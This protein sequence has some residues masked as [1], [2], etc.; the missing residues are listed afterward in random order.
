LSAMSIGTNVTRQ[1]APGRR[2]HAVVAAPSPRKNRLLAALP[3]PEYERVLRSLIP[4]QLSS[5]SVLHDAGDREKHLYFITAGIVSR[6]YTLA[7]GSSTGFAVTGNEGVVGIPSFLG[8]E[9]TLSQAVV[10]GAGHAYRM[11]TQ[12]AQDLFLSGG[13][14]PQLLLRFTQALI[15]QIGQ[16]AVCNRHHHLESQLCRWILSCLDRLPENK[17]SMTQETIAGMLGVRREG[18]TEAAGHLQKAG[19]I[20][21]HRG[22]ISVFDR[23]KLEARACECYGVIK[24]EYARLEPPR[25]QDEGSVKVGPPHERAAKP[26]KAIALMGD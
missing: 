21:Y 9:S 14:L 24:R 10:V 4:V 18:V 2:V 1:S 19:L 17:V 25:W 23:P 20:D 15:T 6:V 13:Q 12:C 26:R 22:H 16:V 8:G 5:S 7:S 11:E 3:Q